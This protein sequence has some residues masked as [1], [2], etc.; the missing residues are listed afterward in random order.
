MSKSSAVPE[1]INGKEVHVTMSG[2]IFYRQRTK[3]QDGARQP[4]YILVAVSDL[5]L[6]VY[7][8]HLRM[9]ELKHIAESVGAE[10]IE[11]PRGQKH[12]K[13]GEIEEEDVE[14]AK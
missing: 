10:L 13:E 2:K 5:N 9:S 1:W 7:G 11:L 8:N 3:L 6:K 14:I 4:R 12:Q